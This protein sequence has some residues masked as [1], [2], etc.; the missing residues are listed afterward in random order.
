[1]NP[2]NYLCS[3]LDRLFDW[4]PIVGI[5]VASLIAFLAAIGIAMIP[6][7]SAAVRGVWGA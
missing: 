1:M 6:D 7:S 3:M 2:I 5:L 4:N